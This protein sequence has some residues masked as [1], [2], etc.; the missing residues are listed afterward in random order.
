[1]AYYYQILLR[2]K[3]GNNDLLFWILPNKIEYKNKTELEVYIKKN[4]S[5]VKSYNDVNS[6]I[7]FET[8]EEKYNEFVE[9]YRNANM[10]EDFI[11]LD[12]T[13]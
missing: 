8:T 7:A 6:L 12:E 10:E 13:E 1:M 2:R 5:I 9:N 4:C 11:T 3:K